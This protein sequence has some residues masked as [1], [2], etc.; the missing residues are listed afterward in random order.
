MTE[1]ITQHPSDKLLSDFAQGRL[2][3]GMSV[4]ISA[5]IERCKACGQK[6]SQME[7]QAI[8][9]WLQTSDSAASEKDF[10]H[11]IDSIVG[12]PQQKDFAVES[13]QMNELHLPNRSVKLPKVLSR[14]TSDGLVWKKLAGGINQATV[15]L[16]DQ[17]QCEFIYMKPGSQ[18]P[19]H[20]HQGNEF[21]L[22]LDG[23]FGDE[24]G[25]YGEADFVSRSREHHHQPASEEGCLCFA[26]LDSPL[27]FTSG[28]ARLMNP[29]LRYRFRRAVAQRA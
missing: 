20:K 12:Q 1:V 3:T 16:D 11:M 9:D 8:V 17:T 21:T 5:H 26:V 22:V 28:V 4:A 24:L 27:K 10:S 19:V 23:S 13:D 14:L 29:Y 6:T 25:S 7:S 2:S 15:V 18:V